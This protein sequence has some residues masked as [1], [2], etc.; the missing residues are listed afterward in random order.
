MHTDCKR[1]G[2]VYFGGHRKGV[3]MDMTFMI[4]L[5]SGLLMSS[6]AM[7]GGLF[8]FLPATVLRFWLKPLIAFA[9]GSLLSGALFHMLPH[10]LLHHSEHHSHSMFW[11]AVGFTL[12]LALD[13]SLELYHHDRPSPH[14][15]RP[16][17]PL[18]LIADGVHNFLGGST[19]AA[20]FMVDL[21]A[22]AAAWLAAA[23]HELPQEIGDFCAIVHAGYSRKQALFYNFLSALSF[24][25]GAILTYFL[26]QSL[27]LTFVVALGA[28]SFI[29][30]A[31]ANLI[32][33]IKQ[34]QKWQDAVL[35]FSFFVLGL[36]LL[37]FTH[38]NH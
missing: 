27:D 15:I 30:I 23:L 21:R 4:I 12:F 2:L 5:G 25:V 36:L 7:I 3:A 26:G 35:S 10:S 38:A 37:F 20:I 6:I 28:G 22:G 9:A 8:V 18:L 34:T 13:Q 1:P 17:G 14:R 16:L 11:L 29:Y 24:P 32:P 33:E 19:I 31:S